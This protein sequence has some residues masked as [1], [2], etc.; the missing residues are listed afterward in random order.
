MEKQS[1]CQNCHIFHVSLCEYEEE[2]FKDK[3]KYTARIL[4]S[5]L[6]HGWILKKMERP[7]RQ[8]KSKRIC[9]SSSMTK[10]HKPDSKNY[11]TSC[12][13]VWPEML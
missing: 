8:L 5:I 11:F 7:T 6:F 9:M 13:Q 3:Y 10:R 12:C 2:L 4:Q 1:L